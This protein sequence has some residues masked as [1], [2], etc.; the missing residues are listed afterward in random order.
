MFLVRPTGVLIGFL[1]AVSIARAEN[2]TQLKFDA[3]YDL[4]F[5]HSLTFG[6]DGKELFVAFEGY[7]L[8]WKLN[9]LQLFHHQ[10]TDVLA[11]ETTFGPDGRLYSIG[12]DWK[13]PGV[14]RADSKRLSLTGGKAVAYV[15]KS[16]TGSHL[17]VDVSSSNQGISNYSAIA[18]NKRRQPILAST[19][20]FTASP[21]PTQSDFTDVESVNYPQLRFSCGGASQLSIFTIMDDDYY[22][23]STAG[24]AVLEFGKLA[25]ESKNSGPR[26]CF[27][28]A[29]LTKQHGSPRAKESVRHAVIDL[30]DSALATDSSGKG[31]LVLD[32]NTNLLSLFRIESFADD[33]YLSRQNALEV[34]L[35]QFLPNADQNATMTE[36]ALDDLGREIHISSN[37]V[38]TVLRFRFDG[39]ELV[40]RGRISTGAPVQRLIMSRDGSNSAIVTGN[41]TFGGDWRVVLIS[42]PT[43]LN[44]WLQVPP[45]FP[46]VLNL[47]KSLNEDGWSAGLPDGILGPQTTAAAQEFWS[48]HTEN[49]STDGDA[50]LK[51]TVLTTFPRFLFESE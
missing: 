30:K 50:D 13:N 20:N 10:R 11:N 37:M 17:E 34:D 38:K 3:V 27:E 32:P 1:I 47:Q 48:Q 6:P 33:H 42:N 51:A 46:S 21:F 19:S 4:P 9:P 7:L 8:Q 12:L 15:R 39:N 23:A 36:M 49:S 25:L 31:V 44:D 16:G 26:E 5:V 29:Q 18:F 35:T 40:S 43:L 2:N 24:Q 22:V 45:S 41:E 14:S 28:V